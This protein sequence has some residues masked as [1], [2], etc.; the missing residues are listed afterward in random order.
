MK[1]KITKTAFDII[2]SKIVD[3][4]PGGVCSGLLAVINV[5]IKVICNAP[6]NRKANVKMRILGALKV[7]E[8]DFHAR[9]NNLG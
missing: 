8:T 2:I 5:K 1:D 4:H 6:F 7:L 9:I 3:A